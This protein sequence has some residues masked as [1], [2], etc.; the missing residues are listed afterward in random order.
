LPQA[1]LCAA[2]QQKVDRGEPV[3]PAEYCS[4]CGGI[5]VLKRTTKGIR[6]FVEVCSSCGR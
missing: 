6:R 4:L 2:C 1:T 3:G 5:L